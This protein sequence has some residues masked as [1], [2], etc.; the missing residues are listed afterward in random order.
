MRGI[1]ALCEC[2][3]KRERAGVLRV[4]GRSGAAPVS[5]GEASLVEDFGGSVGTSG[6]DNLLLWPRRL[7][8]FCL[9]LAHMDNH[10]GGGLCTCMELILFTWG[11]RG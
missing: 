1:N 6:L 5:G 7:I 11:K 3:D 2:R 4:K 9:T 8:L 10:T